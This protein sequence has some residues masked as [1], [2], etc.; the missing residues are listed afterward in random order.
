MRDVA[1]RRS[2][3]VL[4]AAVRRPPAAAPSRAIPAADLARLVAKI[5]RG[6]PLR[7]TRYDGRG[8]GRTVSSLA[9]ERL[10]SLLIQGDARPVRCGSRCRRRCAARSPATPRRWRSLLG[11]LRLRPRRRRRRQRRALPRHQL[12]GRRRAVAGRDAVR[13]ARAQAVR[14]MLGGAAGGVAGAVRPRDAAR[15]AGSTAASAGRRRRSPSRSAPL[16]DVPTLILSGDDDLRT[17][18]RDAA[19]GR[20]A[21]PLG[22]ARDRPGDRPLGARLRSARLRRPRAR[23]LLPRPARRRLHGSKPAARLLEPSAARCRARSRRCRRRAG[24]PA[25]AAARSSPP[26]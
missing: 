3:R 2:A 11:R 17:P 24:C 26:A 18:R 5:G 6:G 10:L 7:G 9:R 20:G 16:P 1:R 22:A 13:P 19:D 8:R 12:R 14:T 15:A 4:V 23:A 21:D 25:A